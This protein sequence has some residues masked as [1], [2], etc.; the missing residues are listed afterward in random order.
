M[1]I[2]EALRSQ[3][4]TACF[5]GTPPADFDD[6]YDLIDHGHID[7]LRLMGLVT[8]IEQHYR[9]QF[10]MNDMVP[11]HFRSINAMAGYVHGKLG[12]EPAAAP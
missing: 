9:L 10:G 5:D 8:F 7:S 4:V 1:S 11:K 2:Q 12:P 6:D 3:V